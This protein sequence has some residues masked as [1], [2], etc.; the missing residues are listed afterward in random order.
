MGELAR[1]RRA[2][3][4]WI[5][6][7][8]LWALGVGVVAATAIAFFAGWSL[9]RPASSGTG[10]AVGAA[11]PA[12]ESLVELLARVDANAVAGNGVEHLTFPDALGGSDEAAVLPIAAPP[13]PVVSAVEPGDA[14][15]RPTDVA[16]RFD[17]PADLLLVSDALRARDWTVRTQEGADG[18]FLVIEGGDTVQAAAEAR[19]RL[20]AAMADVDAPL[21]IEL[22]PR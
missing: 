22:L 1:Q 6:R 8:H 12:D 9:A 18:A 4:L 15:A 10:V 3:D 7:S 16:I 11:E 19:S 17:D 21:M 20:E 13:L 14:G 5:S 2:R